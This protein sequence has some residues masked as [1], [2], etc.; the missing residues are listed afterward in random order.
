MIVTTWIGGLLRH[1]TGR[2][3]ATVSGIALAVAL[4]ASLGSFLTAS[5]STMTDRAV[6]SVAVDWQVEVQPGSDPGTVL[7][8]VRNTHGVRDAQ[9]VGFT[10]STGFRATGGGSTRDTGP[11]VVM[12]L[13]DTYRHTFPREIR[14]LTGATSGVLIA[15]Q[16][17]ANLHVAPGDTITVNL[18]GAKP[19]PV[20]VAGVVD[21]PQAD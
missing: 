4:V 12:G 13:P 5:K 9:S 17:A 20:K 6:G 7:S 1:H 19:A 8:T 15:Q 18:P 3:L 10:H 11:G 21:L 2:L 14:Q 16:T